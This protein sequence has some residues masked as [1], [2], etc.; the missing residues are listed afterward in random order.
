MRCIEVAV[1]RKPPGAV[2]RN[3][4]ACTV[5]LI[6]CLTLAA[7]SADGADDLAQ[8]YGTQIQPLLVRSC[9]KCHGKMPTD[10]DLDLTSFGSAQAIIAKPKVLVDVAERLRLGDMPPK[11]AP[12][13]TQAEREQLLGWISTALDAEAAARAGDPGPVTLR[14]LSNTEYDNAV[15]D[16]TSVDMR[17]T[18][19]REFPVDSVGGE[20]FAN[21]GDAMPVTPELVERYH[22]TARDVAARVVLLPGG[23]RF[24]PST[25]R[26]D[27][28][29]EA[30]KPLRSFH[31]RYAGPNGEPPLAAHL[32]ATLKHRDR[33][34][35]GGAADI[36]GVAA[37]EKL[38]ATYLAALWTG[39]NGKSASPAEVIAQ[40]KQWSEKAALAEAEK[41]RRQT[42]LQSAKKA[43]ESQWASS[44]RVLAESKV[45]E[46]GSVPFEHK[47]SVQRGELLLLTVLPNENHGADSTLVE[48]TIHETAG[49]Q[50][51]WS[52]ADL[53]PNLLKANPWSDKHEARWS[54]LETTST[55]VFLTERHDSS[56]GRPELKSWSIGS[57]P[58]V[59]VNSAAEP[60]KVW[61][62]LPA[63]SV[64]V[65]P[66]QKRPVAIAWT[67]P[68]A[69]ELSV[70]GRVADAHPS[71]GD[72]VSFELSHVAA[73]DLGQALADLGSAST[74]L[75]E[76]GLPPDMLALV[77]EKWHE[78]TTDP[79]PVLAAIK[80]MQDQLF[81]GNYRKNAALAVGNG[82]PAWEDLRRVVARE[83]VQGAARE[84]LFRMVALPAPS[85]TFVVWD[86]LRLEG[87]DGPPLVFAE[88]PELG[89]AVEQASGLKFG[90]HPQGRP[91][92]PSALV[93]AAG[94]EIVI[95]LRKLSAELQKA[96]TLPRFLCADVSLDEAS[97]ETASV[98]AF[99][100]A[101]TGGGGGLA[102]PVAKAEVGDPHAA[103]IVHPRVAAERARPAAEF[104]ALFPPAVLF[105]PIIPRD[106]QGSV[107]LYRR[108]DEPL[109]RLL[110]DE[111]GRA[112]LDRLWSELEFVSEQAFATPI[113]YEGLVQYYRKPNDGAR[114][115]FFYIQL[116]EE[117]IRREE[118]A[119]LA[120]Q[121]AAEPRHLEA[122]LAFAARAWRRPLAD[123]ERAAILAS[124]RVDRAAGAKHDPAF[125][126]ALA[127]V[128]SSPWFLYRVEQPASGSHWQ[129]VSGDELAAR[130]S[131][132]LWD[133]IPD[134]ELRAKAVK[135][136]EPAVMEEQLR[137]MLKDVRVRG[138]AEE[139]GAR[140]LGVR[141]FVA[142]HGRS[143][144]HFPEFTPVLRDALAEEPVR[145]FE[146]LLV[147][148]RPVADVIAADAV[149]INEVL[150]KHYGIPGVTGPQW[151]R[152]EKVS[153]YG[154]G[155]FLG[156]GAVIA[157]QS[158]AA[159]TSPIKRGAWL[160]QVL[161]E[162]L[163]KVP[164]DVPPLPETPPAGLSVREITERHRADPKCAG[165]H[166]RIDPYGMTLE[167]FDAIGRLRPASELKP[168]DTKG[169]LRDGTEIEDIAGLRNYFAGPRREDL[170][171]TLARK[172]TGYALGRAVLTSD[173][174]LVDEVTKT[175][176]NGGRWSDALLVIVRSEQFR[177]IRPTNAV[178]ATPP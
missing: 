22:Q 66:G 106:A 54:F 160:V 101:A 5:L 175:M 117:Q 74:I 85:D 48:W 20:G 153:A 64:F 108:E 148:D 11:D 30:L 28:T 67:S 111:A 145:F 83:R 144:K 24:S 102:E 4:T 113:A 119:F 139:F 53:V 164:P 98:Q 151:R 25:E 10:N 89:A 90:Q 128:L 133:S 6:A 2:R 33:L 96:L 56:A 27:W 126:A 93:T 109:R 162:R 60:I 13:P 70:A 68:I 63:R 157:K 31:A 32:A 49:D 125:R 165:C 58:S 80:A 88:H 73:P 137:R 59:F 8:S 127:R 176:A 100:I 173:R 65:H 140:W 178:A 112:E 141:D 21:V 37:E 107:F 167:R 26:P 16:L 71:G 46:G 44:K 19:A 34:T 23:F 40:T 163:P 146:D 115:M 105:Q 1:R 72:G 76:A 82:F 77:R 69:G 36:A 18:Q 132:L 123:D 61:T 168:G 12:Q 159:R 114:I 78:A 87:G 104:R 122:L 155:G 142:N 149:V 172:L 15:R 147:N 17:P 103:Q 51:T 136:H 150:A 118:K 91:V 116:F 130:L 43:I 97:P 138:M 131:F 55:P 39:L 84:P 110:L 45:A 57:E 124:Y 121:V 143:L 99:L 50:R 174:N 154:R 41:Q 86:R 152:V 158:A 75:P 81:Q 42:A 29:E 14:R 38:D 177:C 47:V 35:R 135:L 161:G 52:V 129:P 9:G 94:T 169:T 95:D 92:P 156:F 120:A 7:A 166:V 3:R 170:L 134:D 62:T 79:A 171:R